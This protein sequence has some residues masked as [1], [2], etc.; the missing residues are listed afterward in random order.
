M[1]K[2]KEKIADVGV[3]SV[4]TWI[5]LVDMKFEKLNRVKIELNVVVVLMDYFPGCTSLGQYDI[6]QYRTSDCSK[7]NI[8]F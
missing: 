5:L 7:C 3:F 1:L 8:L 6:V 2:L 4:C